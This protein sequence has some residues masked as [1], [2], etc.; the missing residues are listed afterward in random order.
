MSLENCVKMDT[1]RLVVGE[2]CDSCKSIVKE[3]ENNYNLLLVIR[4]NGLQVLSAE[5]RHCFWDNVQNMTEVMFRMNQFL[6]DFNFPE[7]GQVLKE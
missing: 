4:K 6:S 7:R 3:I 2:Y 5:E 1:P